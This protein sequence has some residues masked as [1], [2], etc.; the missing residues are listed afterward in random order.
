LDFSVEE[1]PSKSF[2]PQSLASNLARS[3]F[4]RKAIELANSS[5]VYASG[6]MAS[7]GVGSQS[8]LRVSLLW[9]DLRRK[10]PTSPTAALGML[11]IA[12]TRKVRQV[13]LIREL[14]P[15][16]ARSASMATTMMEA[17][18]A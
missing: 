5:V 11:D 1:M 12:H 8:E 10:L 9:D 16:L 6:E 7:E 14:E 4:D 15:A 3:A 18:D 13:D 2:A 17:E